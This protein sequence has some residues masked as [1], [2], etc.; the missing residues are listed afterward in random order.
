VVTDLGALNG[1]GTTEPYDM[2]EL[3]HCVGSSQ[4]EG[5]G[6]DHAFL[7]KD[8]VMTDLHDPGVILGPTSTAW[9]INDSGVIVGSACFTPGVHNETAVIWDHGEII[10]LGTFGGS[11]SS[12]R[13]LND[14]GTVVGCAFLSPG[15]VHGFIYEDGMMEDLNDFLPPSSGWI[16]TVPYSINN[17]GTIV[18]E[19]IYG[20]GFRSF[21]MS[22][23]SEGGFTIYGEGAVGSGG[24]TPG[25]YGQGFPEPG[26]EIRTVLITGLGGAPGLLLFG[27]GYETMTFKPGV[28]IQIL[29]LLPL[30]VPLVLQGTG[31]GA[32][33]LQIKTEI[34]PD[35]TPMMI[36]LQMLFADP[37]G[38]SGFTVSN[39]LEMNL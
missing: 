10:S 5:L 33:L 9:A 30:Q 24:Y 14:H 17:S 12:A 20:G 8:G 3:G 15:V 39:P 35:I 36:T 37:G 18:G 16:V 21:V 31:A 6:F 22:P 23:D 2:N 32:G 4:S 19:G 38:P 26:G 25:F 13:D 1:T 11:T 7:W 29:P 27:S 28:E 34:P